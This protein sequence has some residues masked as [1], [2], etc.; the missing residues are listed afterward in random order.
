M[1]R[2]PYN[3]QKD[4][5]HTRDDATQ[6]Q[7]VP[8]SYLS[9]AFGLYQ[10]TWEARHSHLDLCSS[11]ILEVEGSC[12]LSWDLQKLSRHCRLCPVELRKSL[13]A[14]TKRVG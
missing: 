2:E 12:V 8:E 7:A 9:K 13:L 10:E 6:E 4:K 1:L 5:Q 14:R 11:R 3:I